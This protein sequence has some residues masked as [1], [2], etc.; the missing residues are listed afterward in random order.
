MAHSVEDMKRKIAGLL[1][2]AERTD[3]EEERDAFN[4]K[5]ERLMLRLGIEKAELEAAGVVKPEE[6]IEATR[7]WHGNYSI[8]MIPFVSNV[9]HGFGNL[10][11][12]QS[13]NH[14]GMR[15]TS[16]II[17]HKSD[18]EEFCRLID[19]LHIQALSALKR[20]Q[21]A[22]RE[23]RRYFTDM[24][25]Y[26]GNRSFLAGFGQEVGRRLKEER[27]EEESSA[28]TGAAL[29]LASKM[30]RVMEARDQMYPNHTKARTG[31]RSYSRLALQ[32][33]QRAGKNAD[34]GHKS[35]DSRTGELS[36]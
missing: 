8:V 10:T 1:A 3:N 7:E 21:R 29:V 12:L 15:R 25:K 32:D 17:G 35:F 14:N 9:A 31:A 18:V 20:W 6:V 19:S 24:M 36:N 27:S 22:T 2:K 4:S 11:L 5:A 16:Y 23:E 34:L 13:S 28:S 33:G 30:D 26:D